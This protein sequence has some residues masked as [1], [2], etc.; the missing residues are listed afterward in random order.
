M[1]KLKYILPFRILKENYKI[2]VFLTVLFLLIYKTI[3]F[4]IILIFILYLIYLSKKAPKIVLYAII[5][6]IFIIIRIVI[7]NIIINNK[8]SNN[9][10]TGY[11]KVEKIK[12]TTDNYQVVL[13]DKLIKY[14]S[15][16][17]E[18][19]IPGD[20]YYIKGVVEEP[21]SAHFEG[22]FDYKEYLLNQNIIGIIQIEEKIFY[23]KGLSRYYLNYKINK[24]LDQ[25]FTTDSK[26]MIKALTIGNKDDFEENLLND[27][28]N[29]GVSHL[30]VISGLHV[31]LIVMAIS[32]LLKKIKVK[33]TKQSIITVI[34]LFL[35]YVISGLMI[36]VF[37]VI[38]SYILRIINKKYNYELTS[39][40]IISIN[41]L[42][43][44]LFDYRIIFE[45][46]FILSYLISFGI[47]IISKILSK[48]SNFLASTINSIKISILSILITLPVIININR[49]VNFLSIIYNLI[50]IPFVSYIML[51]LSVISIIIPQFETIYSYIY[52]GFNFITDILSKIDILT[53]TFPRVDIA[54][55][56]IYY[57]LLYIIG[58]NLEEK[59]KIRYLLIIF[60]TLLC[61]WSNKN[62]FNIYD[63]VYFLDLPKGEATLIKQSFNKANI[64]IDTGED[65]Y[66]DII[67]FLKTEG[68][69]KLDAI[70]ISHSDSDH[71][72]MLDEICNEF[73]VKIVYYGIYDNITPNYIPNNIT[74]LAIKKGDIINIANNTFEVISPSINYSHK[75]NNSLVLYS[76]IFGKKYLFTGDIEKEVEKDLPKI[77]YI[78][79]L[80]VAH[81]GS[82]TSTTDEFLNK[83]NYQY[84]I[85]MNGYKNQFSFPSNKVSKKLENKLFVTSEVNTIIIRR[86]RICLKY[87]LKYN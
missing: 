83:I 81:H 51:P 37:R 58:V 40:D 86:N 34:L 27:I 21:S 82:N 64:L 7:N 43:A 8:I 31:N 60:I 16:F 49:D 3:N 47:I 74:K 73:N 22:G 63:E 5:I 77:G 33:E 36:S 38:C 15:Y 29:I 6:I 70:F 10:Y 20:I 55:I 18:E 48:E 30:F 25:V 35:Y 17:D 52:Q 80:K 79:V 85:C 87:S 84:A 62:L 61:C 2:I 72:G 14:I 59:R 76:K 4:F 13:K 57:F 26:G 28:S 65:G 68:I 41:I 12:K 45:Y 39:I 75:N 54:V 11:L 42:I 32:F 69:K 24:Y 67:N 56:I 50:Y 1:R 23:K 44:I 66:D 78:D 19:V 9:T 71:V 46:S 53:F